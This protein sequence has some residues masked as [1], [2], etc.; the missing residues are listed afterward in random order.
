MAS[1]QLELWQIFSHGSESS[2]IDARL[3]NAMPQA[4]YNDVPGT[5]CA[6]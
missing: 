2:A 6:L 4:L 3:P 1:H 5:T